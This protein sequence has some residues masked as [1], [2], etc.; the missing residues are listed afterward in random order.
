M[1]LLKLPLKLLALPLML[2]LYVFYYIGKLLSNISAYVVGLF[3][4]VILVGVA[5][6]GNSDRRG[7]GLCSSPIFRNVSG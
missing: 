3:M 6:C 1:K 5:E 2:V 4:L 7:S